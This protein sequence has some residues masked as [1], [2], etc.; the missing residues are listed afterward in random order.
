VPGVTSI[1]DRFS[2]QGRVAV[3][4][5]A[6][7]G[8]GVAFAKGLAEAG[9][10]LA[11]GARRADRLAD[12]CKLVADAGRRAIAVPTDVAS[13]PDCQALVDAAMAEFG[14]VDILVNNAGIGTAVPATRE[15]VEQFE[16]VVAVNL[17]GCYWMAQACGRVMKPG[18]SIVNISS[19]LG[20]TTAG[21]PQAAYTATKAGLIGLTRDL[22]Q[23][24]SGRK[25]IRVNALAPGF[26]DTEMTDQY[27]PGYVEEQT[28]RVVLGRKGQADELTAALIFLASDAGSYVTGQTLAVD[29]GT[30]IT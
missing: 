20:I 25:G 1:L 8:L 15:T 6:S 4:T 28:K 29:G 16:Q 5:G 23:Q 30:T 9:A 12:T 2:L 18:S 13:Q 27:P 24:W 10:D 17:C 3:V 22:A 7:S 11:L 26:F 14:R 19:I 21:L